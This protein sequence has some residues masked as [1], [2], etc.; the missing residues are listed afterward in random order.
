MRTNVSLAYRAAWRRMAMAAAAALIVV[1]PALAHHSFTMFDMTKRIALVGTVTSFE[2]S[3][4]HAYIEIDVPGEDGELKHWS[5][6]LGSPSILQ[7]SGWKFS[8]LKKG[9]KTTLVINP[10]KS[11]QAGGFLYTATLPDGR[12]LS[13]GPMRQP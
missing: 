4:P 13:N 11:G 1:A 7:S 9:D 12:V 2:W 5:I 6:E 8:S 10:L 3:N